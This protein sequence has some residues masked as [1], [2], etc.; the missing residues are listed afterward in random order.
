MRAIPPHVSPSTT[1]RRTLR[2]IA[3]QD[4]A[5]RPR[6]RLTNSIPALV[7]SRLSFCACGCFSQGSPGRRPAGGG[8]MDY[9][10]RRSARDA[11]SARL[12]RFVVVLCCRLGGAAGSS[13]SSACG[14]ATALLLLPPPSLLRHLSLVWLHHLRAR[15]RDVIRGSMTTAIATMTAIAASAAGTREQSGGV[16]APRDREMQCS[17][18]R[19]RWLRDG[20]RGGAGLS[21]RGACCCGVSIVI[22]FYSL[23]LGAARRQ[24]E[25]PPRRR[26]LLL[27]SAPAKPGTKTR[28]P[29]S[30]CAASPRRKKKRDA[31]TRVFL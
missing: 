27:C 19:R 7:N 15:A 25:Q 11:A 24:R 20:G 26:L 4:D 17:Y 22:F 12:G 16:A 8:G 30:H 23:L 29:P 9:F 28:L 6:N 18:E 1:P 21:R 2:A 31:R 3:H 5:H 14:G 10:V 13:R